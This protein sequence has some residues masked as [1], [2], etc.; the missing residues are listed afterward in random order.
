MRK[1]LSTADHAKLLHGYENAKRILREGR[2]HGHLQDLVPSIAPGR[3]RED[4]PVG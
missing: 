3:H 4:R 1:K 2:R